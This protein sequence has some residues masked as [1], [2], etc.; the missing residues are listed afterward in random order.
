MVPLTVTSQQSEACWRTSSLMAFAT[1]KLPGQY[2]KAS[3]LIPSSGIWILCS[4]RWKRFP[5]GLAD[6]FE[7]LGRRAYGALEEKVLFCQG[8]ALSSA[9][10]CHCCTCFFQF[11]EA[12]LD[13]CFAKLS[14]YPVAGRSIVWTIF[15]KI[16]STTSNECLSEHRLCLILPA[17]SR[18]R[19]LPRPSGV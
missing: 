1:L 2:M 10:C 9:D 14:V 19:W 18:S 13:L 8:L 11:C 17:T 12:Y 5:G 15:G 6:A 7:A 4:V 16:K 3:E